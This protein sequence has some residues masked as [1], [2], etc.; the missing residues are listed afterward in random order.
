MS[1][2]LSAALH[3]RGKTLCYAEIEHL[4]TSRCLRRVNRQSFDFEVMEALRDPKEGSDSLDRLAEAMRQQLKGTAAPVV[5]VA[6]HPLDGF[7][8]F[9][10][11]STELSVQERKR[12]L[13]RQSALVTGVRSPHSLHL[14]SQTVRTTTDGDEAPLMW[15]HVLALP[16]EVERRMDALLEDCPVRSHSWMVS[17]EAA[18][19]LM[20]RIERTT[21]SHEEAL[22]PYS[23]AIG[24][25]PAHTEYALSRNRE[26]YHAH[27]TQAADSP[28][29]RAYYAVGFLNRID[30]PLTGIGRLFVYG[31]DVDLEAYAPLKPIFGP[32]PER[33]DPLRV[34][35]KGD[36][37][38]PDEEM[39]SYLLSIGA[40]MNPSID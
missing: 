26:W 33:L 24:E 17:S 29:D 34:V 14:A 23:L 15:V 30:V 9:T 5:K 3:L 6:I 25:Y 12:E 2:S 10:P 20:G 27:Y 31:A 28:E 1:E 35:Q 18:A 7:S 8:F 4:E 11:L 13:V 37:V 22:R 21:P 19:R 38:A 32:Q 39:S 16:K 36:E 40:G